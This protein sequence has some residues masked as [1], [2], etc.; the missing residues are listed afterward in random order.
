MLLAASFL[1]RGRGTTA[2]AEG[3][4]ERALLEIRLQQTADTRLGETKCALVIETVQVQNAAGD[5]RAFRRRNRGI[6]PHH[7]LIEEGDELA[8]ALGNAGRVAAL[9]D[10]VLAWFDITLEDLGELEMQF[11]VAG[12]P[13]RASSKRAT[14]ITADCF[15]A[16]SNLSRSAS[17][18]LP[19]PSGTQRPEPP[20]G[21]VRIL[22]IPRR[23]L[24]SPE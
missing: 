3:V 11:T 14:A 21:I 6:V 4:H 24:Q 17:P 7:R 18:L 23:P 2:R 13:G 20:A 9:R 19:K 5:F 15:R 10:D 22:V 8:D 16:S 12:C 1:S